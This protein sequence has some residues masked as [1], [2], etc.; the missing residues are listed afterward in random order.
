MINSGI[1]KLAIGMNHAPIDHPGEKRGLVRPRAS[2]FLAARNI[3]MMNS[4]TIA[5]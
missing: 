5:N 4:T 1:T 3:Q 2:L